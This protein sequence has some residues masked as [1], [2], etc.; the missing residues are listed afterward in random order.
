MSGGHVLRR[1]RGLL[2][3]LRGSAARIRVARRA[4][5]WYR[6]ISYVWH[7]LVWSRIVAGRTHM[8]PIELPET[9]LR[10]KGIQAPP[11][12]IE[13]ADNP[14]AAAI[15][16]GFAAIYALLFANLRRADLLSSTRH[17]IPGPGF[18]GV[19]LWDSAFIAQVW[20]WWDRAVA[21]DVLN[22]VV[23]LRDGDRLQHVV[24]EFHQSSYTQPPLIAWSL[25][26]LLTRMQEAE[27]VAIAGRHFDP[28]CAYQRWLDRH[29][30]LDNGLYAWAH[31]YESGV[32]N[33]PRF[34]N[35]DESVLRDTR[36][37]GAVDFSSYVVLQLD[38]LAALATRLRRPAAAAA[39]R[40]AARDLRRRIDNLLWDRQDELYYDRDGAGSPV[41]VPTIAS[42]MPLWAGVPDA[43][44]AALL[45]RR[46]M[47]A[48][49]FGTRMPLPSVARNAPEFERDMWRG[50]VWLNTAYG[51]IQ[52]MLRYGYDRD[53]ATLAWRLCTGVYHVY[54]RERRMY[55]FYDP[56]QHHTRDLR[57]KQGNRWKA[58]T[59]GTRPQP[60]FVGWTGLAN[61]LL[62]EVVLGLE[63][64]P[65]RLTLCPRPPA[66]A[67]GLRLLLRLPQ[68][69]VELT[70][71]VESAEG[72]TGRVS[73]GGRKAAFT[74]GRGQRLDLLAVLHGTA[75]GT[76]PCVS[77]I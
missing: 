52:G 26:Q 77:A 74:A 41:R 33:A 37:L 68:P 11:P 17:A 35:V 48:D 28:L 46:I 62:L 70:L 29:R 61:N 40:A 25:E 58:L 34:S 5:R 60:D 27:A 47:S 19:Y 23:E 20:A 32:E 66:A 6:G 2:A 43:G 14:A 31:P 45:V 39:H 72:V 54:K 42:L 15:T 13:A 7:L 9:L 36:R 4:G 30:R 64:G 73:H 22:A 18:R 49:A 55:E 3:R 12:H 21:A 38:A 1:L 59:L 8:R 24:T 44:R 50:P 69:E 10:R 67:A 71:Q 53:A 16:D 56:D 76:P 75:E 65:S 51:V 63:A 57:R